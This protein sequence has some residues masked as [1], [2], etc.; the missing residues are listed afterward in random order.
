MNFGEGRKTH[1]TAAVLLVLLVVAPALI[2]S[3]AV[4]AIVP[5]RERLIWTGWYVAAVYGLLF[6]YAGL[7]YA[8][9]VVRNGT[10]ARHYLGACDNSVEAARRYVL[11]WHSGRGGDFTRTEEGA[12]INRVTEIF[13]LSEETAAEIVGYTKAEG[14]RWNPAA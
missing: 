5:A 12:L 3:G 9:R 13:G 14:R 8:V 1:I 7:A 6:L 2:M 11:D 4:G 10:T